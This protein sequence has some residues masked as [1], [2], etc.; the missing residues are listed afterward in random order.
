MSLLSALGAQSIRFGTL[1]L[2]QAPIARTGF[3][4]SIWR[5]PQP[6]FR[7]FHAS[8]AIMS[9]S[10]V[11]EPAKTGRAGCKDCKDKIEKDAVRIGKVTSSPFSDDGNMVVW[12][13]YNCFFKA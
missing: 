7:P 6:H 13:H 11:I 10:F 4:L 8:S 3:Q 5:S 9:T 2:R 12:Y 1:V